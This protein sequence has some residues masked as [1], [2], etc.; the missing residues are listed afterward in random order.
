M[1]DI[2]ISCPVFGKDVPTGLTNETIILST[3][4]FALTMLCP[5]CRK[6]HK[7]TRA[8]AWVADAKP[9]RQVSKNSN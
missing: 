1:A 5:A 8:D 3:L 7:W 2:M 6:T 4:D 9:G